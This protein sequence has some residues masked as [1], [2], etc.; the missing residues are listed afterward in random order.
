MNRFNSLLAVFISYALAI[1]L[2]Y[3][4]L[5]FFSNYHI[6][7]QIVLADIIATIIIYFSS[8][9]FKNSSVYDPYWSIVPVFIFIQLFIFTS[10]SFSSIPLLM[11]L[12]NI[13]FWSVR[14]TS[15]W[16]KNW[17]GMLSEDWRYIDM[18]NYSG[19]FFEFSNFFGIHLLPT[20]IVYACCIPIYFICYDGYVLS[21]YTYLGFCI[22]FIGVLYEIISDYQLFK[23]RENKNRDGNIINTGLWKYS[24]HPNYWGE[25][26]FWWGLYLY[27]VNFAPTYMILSPIC[28]TL[29]FVYISIPW[30]ENKILKT[31]SEYKEYQHKTHFLIPELAFIKSIIKK[32]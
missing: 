20:L 15:N 18:R 25:I 3:L 32:Q 19:N 1:F 6:L 13:L 17:E 8:V 22:S 9:I 4:S 10:S 5:S 23:F 26:L 12:F 30:I 24:R 14:L 2:A 27:V 28:M 21:I 7:I 16:I 11:I 31:R 29:M